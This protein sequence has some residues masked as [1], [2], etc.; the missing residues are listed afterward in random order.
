M[1]DEILMDLISGKVA[2]AKMGNGDFVYCIAT[3]NFGACSTTSRTRDTKRF[4]R[5]LR[6]LLWLYELAIFIATGEFISPY[7]NRCGYRCATGNTLPGLGVNS[8]VFTDFTTNRA[9]EARCVHHN[10]SI[11]LLS[12]CIMAVCLCQLERG[13][14]S[15]DPRSS[16]V[17][18]EL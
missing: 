9:G 13:N 4:R 5:E 10:K 7:S 14:P 16:R 17:H 8:N 18:T 6:G 11:L 1:I 2:V 3:Y 12:L 15:S